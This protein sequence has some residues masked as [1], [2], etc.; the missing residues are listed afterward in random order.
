MK[1][2]FFTN[3]FPP[4]IYGGAGVHVDYLTRELSRFMDVEVHCFGDQNLGGNRLTATGHAPDKNIVCGDPRFLKAVGAL[5][6]NLRMVGNLKDADIVHCHTWYTHFAGLVARQLYQ[7]PMVL[8]THS[9]EPSRPW[10][11]EQLGNAYHLSSWVERMAMEQSDGIIAVSQGMKKDA[12]K[13]MNSKVDGARVHSSQN[14]GMQPRESQVSNLFNIDASKIEVIYNGIDLDEYRPAS[15]KEALK[16]YSIDIDIPYVLFVGRITRQ[17]G[18]IHLVHAVRHISKNTQIVLCAG[19]PD[20]QDI[21]KEMHAA[22]NEAKKYH[23]KIIW[24]E[25]MVPKKEVI[26]LY[27]HAAVFCCPSVY[28][29]FGII[30]LEA[31]ACETAVVASAVGGIPEIIVPGQTGVLVPF[32]ARSDVDPEPRDPAQYALQLAIEINQLLADPAKRHT[33]EKAA[34]KRVEAVFGWQAIAKATYEYY[35]RVVKK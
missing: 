28:E 31:M 23:D 7:I 1:V 4:N 17:K 12:L 10:K 3:E 21:A 19:A 15:S 2:V 35:Q 32:E 9:F 20:T 22:V 11:V 6:T 29:P 26:Q 18:I 13:Y 34:R 25:E 24:I 14:E 16:K 30:N 5:S 27:T 33:F 8:T